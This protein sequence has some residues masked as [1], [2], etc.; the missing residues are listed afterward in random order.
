MGLYFK[1]QLIHHIKQTEVFNEVIDNSSYLDGRAN[2]VERVLVLTSTI[3]ELDP[4]NR[5]LR[6]LLGFGAGATNVQAQTDIKS[7]PEKGD[8][9]YFATAQRQMGACWWIWW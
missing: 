9:L 3:T 8:Q 2:G 7:H 6:Y 4:G 5:A 1:S